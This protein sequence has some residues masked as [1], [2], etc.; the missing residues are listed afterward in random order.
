[1]QFARYE[2]VPTSVQEAVV[3]KVKGH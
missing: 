2:A 3:A 1:M